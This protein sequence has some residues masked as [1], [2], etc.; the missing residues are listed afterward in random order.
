M[1]GTYAKQVIE[2]DDITATDYEI[3]PEGGE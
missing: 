3:Q 2:A 1:K